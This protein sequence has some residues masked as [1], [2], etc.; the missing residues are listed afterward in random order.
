MPFI[1]FVANI[2]K[3]SELTIKWIEFFVLSLVFITET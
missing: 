2:L 3:I 1:R